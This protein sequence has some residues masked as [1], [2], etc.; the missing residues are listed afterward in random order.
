MISS[1]ALTVNVDRQ[2]LLRMIS[3]VIET[4]FKPTSPFWTGRAMDLFF[5][6]IC[7]FEAYSYDNSFFHNQSF[8]ISPIGIPIDCSSRKFNVKSICQIFR[9]GENAA[10]QP[11]DEQKKAFKFSLLGAFND[12]FN[13]RFKVYRGKKEVTDTG[14]IIEVD[15]EPETDKW[16]S[17][18]ANQ[19]KGT[20]GYFMPPF[21]SAHE[22]IWA[23]E[24]MLCVPIALE[25]MKKKFVNGMPFWKFGA[26]LRNF[27]KDQAYCRSNGDCPIEGTLDLFSCMGAPI[28]A[29]LPH[30][31]DT[32]PSLLENIG[33]G[34]N[35]KQ[36]AHELTATVD[37]VIF[38][39]L[40]SVLHLFN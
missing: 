26:S 15:G 1:L 34:L 35:P 33:S 38:Y 11:I 20:D 37:L 6:G 5:D 36:K 21:L 24:R 25:Y 23:Y 27:S 32:H 2:G 3:E 12:S 30:F 17:A 10:I 14:R 16:G 40:R 13:G 29:T 7:H 39:I 22:P 31:L 19:F 8:N 4:M 28:I 18:E 9:N